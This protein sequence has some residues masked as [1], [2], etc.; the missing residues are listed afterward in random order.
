MSCWSACVIDDAP[1]TRPGPAKTDKL[2]YRIDEAVA[3]TG[4][5]RTSLYE[6]IKAGA[7]KTRKIGRRTLIERDEL[8]RALRNLPVGDG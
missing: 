7:L 6:M 1:A 5:G 2:A 8:E 3:A 4:I